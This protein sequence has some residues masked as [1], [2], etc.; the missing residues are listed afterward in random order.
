VTGEP[1]GFTNWRPSQPDNQ[2]ANQDVAWMSPVS[3]NGQWGD[4]SHG[5]T[6]DAYVVEF[7]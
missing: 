5:S 4:E 6:G 1:W 2:G 3:G 7:E